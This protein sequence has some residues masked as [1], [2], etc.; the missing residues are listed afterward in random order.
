MTASSWLIWPSCC[1]RNSAL[2]CRSACGKSSSAACDLGPGGVGIDAVGELGE[3]EQIAW[4]QIADRLE[5]GDRD[6]PVGAERAVVEDPGHGER[7]FDAVLERDVDGVADLEVEIVGRVLV[8]H[9]RRRPSSAVEAARPT[10]SRSTSWGNATGSTAV[11]CLSSSSTVP[12]IEPERRHRLQ[13]VELRHVLLDLRRQALERLVGDDVVGRDR[14][15]ED[16]AERVAQRRGE[17]RCGADQRDADHQRRRGACG[18]A[19]RPRGV[20][21]C[22]LCRACRTASGS[23]RRAAG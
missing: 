15:V 19:R 20:L 22:Q 9:Q 6:V 17:H 13:H 16:A 3:H 1:S 5:R 4:W 14:L 12:K 23:V 18:A 8:H 7:P 10:T 21:P 11:N 2:L